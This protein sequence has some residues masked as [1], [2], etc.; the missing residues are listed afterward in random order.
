MKKLLSTILLI[1]LCASMSFAQEEI[2]SKRNASY[3]EAGGAGLFF[4][5][6]YERQLSK[7]PGF[8]WRV[9]LGGY[10]EDDFYVTYTTGFSYLFD[11]NEEKGAFLEL[12]ANLTIAREYKGIS[13][14]SRN[15]DIFENIVPGLNYRKHFNN[16]I[17]FKAGINAI[18]NENGLTPWLNTGFG[19][20]F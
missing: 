15:A 13:E 12:G 20:M 9:G 17:L 16:D 14:E 2:A 5:I 6:N 3:V 1:F 8:L 10:S 19:I 11:L 4:S 18:I 7:T